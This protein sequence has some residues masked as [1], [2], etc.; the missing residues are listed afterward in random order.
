MNMKVC[1]HNRV[2]MH[3]VHV[4]KA[5]HI[6][7]SKSLPSTLE[8]LCYLCDTLYG[9]DEHVRNTKSRSASCK[10][11]CLLN[12]VEC[13]AVLRVTT[14]CGRLADRDG[15]RRVLEASCIGPVLHASIHGVYLVNIR[16]EARRFI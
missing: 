1:I 16:H 12:A 15:P 11:R 9:P 6:R 5:M 3:G 2:H 4:P 8:Y 7:Q 13:T 14:I 10:H